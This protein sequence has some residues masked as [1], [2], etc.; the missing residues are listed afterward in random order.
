VFGAIPAQRENL[1]SVL[2]TPEMKRVPDALKF[3]WTPER[4]S[5]RNIPLAALPG[6][7][8]QHA[9]L[10]RLT[11]ALH[12]AGVPLLMG[13]DA[14]ATAAVPPGVSAHDELQ[15]LVQSGLTPYEALR[16]ATTNVARFLGQ[17]NE[18]G[19]IR[20]GARADLLLLDADPRAEIGATR[21]SA[22]VML[23]GRW[24]DAAAR[25]SLRNGT[26]P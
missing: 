26:L 16:T 9:L 6:F 19:V 20:P 23:R 18:F 14:L 2:N 13:T 7:R 11:L 4:N 8:N 10:R 1:D 25:D 21:R 3:D 5:Y 12:K 15:E 22:G 17:P 24:F